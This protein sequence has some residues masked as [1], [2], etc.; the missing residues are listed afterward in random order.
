MTIAA[1]SRGIKI[2]FDKEIVTNPDIISGYE[3]YRPTV[4][5]ALAS[6]NYSGYPPSNG[7]DNNVGA[8]WV[9]VWFAPNNDWLGADFGSNFA[10]AKVSI[11]RNNNSSPK[12]YRIEGS[13]NGSSWNT[14]HTGQLAAIAGWSDITFTEAT[15]RYWR[16]FVIDNWNNSTLYINELSFWAT[17][18]VYNLSGWSVTGQEYTWQPG[19][20]LSAKNYVVSRV[21]KTEDNLGVIVWLTGAGRLLDPDGLVTVNYVKALGNLAGAYS[22]Q[23]E[24]FSITFTPTNLTVLFPP[25]APEYINL[26]LS[27]ELHGHSLAYVY[28]QNKEYVDMTISATATLCDTNG[29]PI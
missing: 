28:G 11:H 16:M 14:V 3:L 19:G 6:R 29:I 10:I 13:A 20:N 26:T 5:T 25:N 8:A 12:N 24:D 9:P 27:G 1:W 7:F 23:V 15:Y 21:T 18:P 22:S 2:N 4:V 17:R